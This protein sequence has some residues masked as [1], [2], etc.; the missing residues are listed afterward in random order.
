MGAGGII[1]I[2]KNVRSALSV[3]VTSSGR[4]KI[5]HVLVASH[6]LVWAAGK[7]L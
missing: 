3:G 7:W 5:W 6:A 1:V 4:Y 2:L